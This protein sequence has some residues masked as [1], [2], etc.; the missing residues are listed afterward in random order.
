MNSKKHISRTITVL[1]VVLIGMLFSASFGAAFS[2]LKDKATQVD[3][4]G[5]VKVAVTYLKPGEADIASQKTAFELSLDTHSVDLSRY[6]LEA[7]SYLQFDQAEPMSGATW[8]STGSG[9]HYKGTLTFS[10]PVP[11]G[12]KSISLHIRGID[13]IEN[14]SFTWQ[15]SE[16]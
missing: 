3:S 12:T 9:H 11:Q 14:R 7:I 6:D 4:Q 15:L 16:L 8:N 1:T 13:N 2:F 10:Q 5:A